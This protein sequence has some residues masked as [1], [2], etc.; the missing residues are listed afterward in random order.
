[1]AKTKIHGEYLDP[2]VISG[3]TQVTAVGA[4][5]MLI[6]DATDN[7]L[8][9]ALLSDL[10]ETV[11]ATPSFTSATISGDLTVDTSTL[12]VD[13]S[14]NRVGIG[15]TSP[16]HQFH[17][18]G[19]T[20]AYAAMRIESTST[21]HGSIINMGDSS[22]DDYGQIVQF[23][24]SAGEGGRMRFIAGA[25][26]TMNLRGGNVGIGTASPSSI[27][28]IEGNTNEYASAPILYFGSTSTANAAVR[29]WAIG[30]AD[31]NYGNFHIFRGTS[32]GSD[33]IGNNGRV[34]TISSSGNVLVGKNATTFSTEGI[35]AFSSA[36][37]NGS[38]INITNDGGGTLNLN[39]K[40]SDG[41]IA[42]FYKDST[43]VGSIGTEGTDLTIGS[44]GAGFQFLE[45]ENKIRPFNMSTNS[46]SNG[47][48]DLGRSNAK[49]KDLYLSGAI[50]M[51]SD[52]DDYEEG[53]FTPTCSA[54]GTTVF[55][56]K[57]TK[58]GDLVTLVVYLETTTANSGTSGNA[59]F[60]G[61]PFTSQGNGWSVGSLSIAQANPVNGS[62]L[63]V[64]V[65]ANS[66][67]ID[68]K[69]NNDSTM[70]G[71]DVDAG[72]IIWTVSYKAA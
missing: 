62:P 29:D 55:S 14:N 20:S 48:V 53:T 42:I 57:Y 64:R 1:M 8:K 50:K 17:I 7:A 39:R 33:P 59:T 45:S 56:A 25:T 21:S 36:D 60:T 61:L 3:Q 16:T 19:P 13:S 32:T 49:F 66:S 4:D 11:G 28:H 26:E 44:G 5:S 70:A 6:F 51:D 35:V 58:V 71:S 23:A 41:D 65:Q 24:S 18:K 10:I 37:S 54:V 27:L 12:K 40:T 38:R 68:L 46:A 34:F 43:T 69:K 63:H 22:D 72:H 2:S 52:L 47:V 67:A 30:P 15:T 9:K 31:D